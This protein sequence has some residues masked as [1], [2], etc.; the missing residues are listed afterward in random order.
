MRLPRVISLVLVFLLLFC[1][2]EA[3]L[4]DQEEEALSQESFLK[5]KEEENGFYQKGAP[6]LALFLLAGLTAYGL[7]FW[8]RRKGTR[9]DSTIRIVSVR[10]IGQREKI[11][12]LDIL[13]ERVVLGVTA[14]NISLL[15]K[16]PN[17]FAQNLRVEDEQG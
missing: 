15:L 9:Q 6:A 8:N 10:P 1:N 7:F 12:I 16:A 5:E 17:S 14:H 4:W 2:A 11:A 13:G 3:A